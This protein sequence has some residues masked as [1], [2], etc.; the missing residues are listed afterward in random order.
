M[1]QRRLPHDPCPAPQAAPRGSPRLPAQTC[2]AS[3]LSSGLAR[4]S[5]GVLF[6]A[7]LANCFVTLGKS[8]RRLTPSVSTARCCDPG[9]HVTSSLA[10]SLAVGGDPGVASLL[11]RAGGGV[12]FAQN[13][14]GLPGHR[15][16]AG[17]GSRPQ[18]LPAGLCPG[19]LSQWEDGHPPLKERSVSGPLVSL[20]GD[21][22][23]LASKGRRK[24]KRDGPYKAFLSAPRLPLMFLATLLGMQSSQI[25]DVETPAVPAGQGS[26]CTGSGPQ[27]LAEGSI[28][29]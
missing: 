28:N 25:G 12:P 17:P 1:W 21:C 9:W 15:E 20:T 26:A 18:M 27:D 23:W 14:D 4:P 8:R 24:R 22:G 13:L 5:P 7:Q 29:L 19:L 6:L 2:L 3:N 16:R 10:G 11:H